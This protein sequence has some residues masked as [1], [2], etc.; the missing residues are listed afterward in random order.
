MLKNLS[1]LQNVEIKKIKNLKENLGI[2]DNRI[3]NCNIYQKFKKQK[4]DCRKVVLK[5]YQ[6]KICRIKQRF[7]LSEKKTLNCTQEKKCE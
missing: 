6:L 7:Q 3:R 2:I 1:R 4:T 5:R